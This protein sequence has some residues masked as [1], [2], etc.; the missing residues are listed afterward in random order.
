MGG[1]W[2]GPIRAAAL[3][4]RLARPAFALAAL[5]AR[6]ATTMVAAA[7]SGDRVNKVRGYAGA[8]AGT[9]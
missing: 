6:P 2:G 8:L 1:M 7:R 5:S 4:A 9:A 3:S